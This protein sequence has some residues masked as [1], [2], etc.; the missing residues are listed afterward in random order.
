MNIFRLKEEY[1]RFFKRPFGIPLFYPP[2][3]S[4]KKVKMMI[5][6]FSPPLIITVGDVVSS[7]LITHDIFPDIMIIDNRSLRERILFDFSF[8]L[9]KNKLYKVLIVNNPPST[10][11]FEAWSG[12]RK[13]MVSKK[14]ILIHVI[15]EEDLLAVPAIYFSPNRSFIIYGQPDEAMVVLISSRCTKNKLQD[16]LVK[17]NFPWIKL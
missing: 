3:I 14:R 5:D 10:I 17:I 1:K 9:R 8:L 16:L 7:T 15:G 6:D 12:I 2:E 4:V 13:C 11:T